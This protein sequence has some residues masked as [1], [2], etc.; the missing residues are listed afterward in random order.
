MKKLKSILKEVCNFAPLV[1]EKI[2]QNINK[3]K[4]MGFHDLAPTDEMDASK[5]YFKALDWALKN[6]KITN[7]A[8]SGPY[9]SGKSS[10]IRGFWHD[11]GYLTMPN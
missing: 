5:E 10:I 2:K 3:Y 6:D 7:I 1:F 8:L 9:G 11:G 4:N